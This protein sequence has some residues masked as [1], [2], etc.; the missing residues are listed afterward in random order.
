M[1]EQPPLV[2]DK[3][4]EWK[5]DPGALTQREF[6][7]WLQH[8]QDKKTGRKPTKDAAIWPEYLEEAF[9]I[10]NIHKFHDF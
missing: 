1:E 6:L 9:Q 10:G 8:K 5:R 7:T 4:G 3:H 2:L